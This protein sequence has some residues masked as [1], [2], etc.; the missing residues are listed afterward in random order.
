M[1]A[2][3]FDDEFMSWALASVL[4]TVS[5]DAFRYFLRIFI[6]FFNFWNLTDYFITLNNPPH[7]S[8]KSSIQE[9]EVF[10]LVT[11]KL[12][13]HIFRHFFNAQYFIY[14]LYLSSLI[15]MY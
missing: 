10:T 7:S 9:H 15:N 2:S 4:V 11:P 1:P 8:F 13:L 6:L 5:K 14:P 3:N 12:I